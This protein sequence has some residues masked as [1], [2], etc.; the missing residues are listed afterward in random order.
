M[1]R[2]Q[3][4]VKIGGKRTRLITKDGKITIEAAP[5]LEWELQAEAVRRLR[6]LPE[7]ATKASDVKPGTF[8]FA[9]DFAAGKRDATKAKAT[10]VM[11]GDPDLRIYA[12]SGRLLLI[13]YKNA[14]GSL[15]K[16][17][18]IKGKKRGGQVERHALLRALGYRVEVIKAATPDEC[19]TASVALVRG[20]LAAND[21]GSMEKMA[22]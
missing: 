13:E 5:V 6:A 16:D 7:C 11:A 19:A 12:S 9:A 14:E 22:A 21:N 3:Q 17:K 20:W 15:S 2:T 8:T 1:T 18:I 10:G 4:T